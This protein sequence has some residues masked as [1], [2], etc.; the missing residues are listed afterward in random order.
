MNIPTE[1][2]LSRSAWHDLVQK[3]KTER[4]MQDERRRRM[5]WSINVGTFFP[6]FFSRQNIPN[7][8]VSV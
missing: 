7:L 6:K 1:V 8:L 3:L 2:V 4:G 5:W